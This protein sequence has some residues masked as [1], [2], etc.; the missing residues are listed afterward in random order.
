VFVLLSGHGYRMQTEDASEDVFVPA[1]YVPGDRGKCFRLAEL[2][3]YLANGLGPGTQFWFIDA[4]RVPLDLKPGELSPEDRNARNAQPDR[5]LLFSAAP[6]APAW[7]RSRFPT[8]L[9][10]A[11]GGEGR[12]KEWIEGHY[13]VTAPRVADVVQAAVRA[14]GIDVEF[15]PGSKVGRVWMVDPDPPPVELTVDVHGASDGD[16]YRLSLTG[17]RPPQIFDFRW[18]D[19][20]VAVPPGE[21]YVQLLLA[22]GPGSGGFGT[23]VE[24]RQPPPETMADLNEPTAVRFDRRPAP[25]RD[26]EEGRSLTQ[27]VAVSDP[28]SANLTIRVA[29]E[30]VGHTMIPV[31]EGESV[32]VELCDLDEPIARATLAVPGLRAPAWGWKLRDVIAPSALRQGLLDRIGRPDDLDVGLHL[33]DFMNYGAAHVGVA[34]T[35]PSALLSLLGTAAIG[36]VPPYKPV[37]TS[38]QTFDELPPGGSAVYVL[39]SG[40]RGT[41]GIT[42][43]PMMAEL[44]DVPDMPAV[45]HAPLFVTPGLHRL[46]ITIPGVTDTV[47]GTVA[48]PNRVTLVV[49]AAGAGRTQLYQ[50]ALPV[51]HVRHMGSEPGRWLDNEGFIRHSRFGALVQRRFGEGRPVLGDSSPAEHAD[52]W[53]ELIS[54]RWPDPLTVIVAAYEL[55]RRGATQVDHPDRAHLE[56]LAAVAAHVAPNDAVVLQ[57]LIRGHRPSLNDPPLVVDGVLAADVLGDVPDGM[58]LSYEGPWTRWRAWNPQGTGQPAVQA[59]RDL[60]RQHGFERA[61][62]G[63]RAL[64]NGHFGLPVVNFAQIAQ[65]LGGRGREAVGGAGVDAEGAAFVGAALKVLEEA[66]PESDV[67][68]APN[69]RRAALMQSFLAQQAEDT[70]RLNLAPS[71]RPKVVFD[72]QDLDWVRA[73]LPWVR[74]KLGV[75][76]HLVRPPFSDVAAPLPEEAR[77]AVLG[78]WGTGLYGAPACARSL[79]RDGDYDALVHLGDVYYTGT[80]REV[81]KHFLE[82]W[83]QIP[84]AVSRACNSNHEMYSGG[85]GYFGETLPAFAQPSSAFLLENEH[86]VL[87]GLDTAYHEADLD[88]EQLRWLDRA[89]A[90]LQGRRLVLFSHHPPFS[91]LASQGPLLQNKLTPLLRGGTVF[92]WYWGHE[93]LLAL[94]DRHEGWGLHGRCVGHSGYPYRR[95]RFGAA[96][97]V[98]LPEDLA[99]RYVCSVKVAPGAWA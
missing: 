53:N 22:A 87:A 93:H 23:L 74:G 15:K 84:K 38:F 16:E 33:D 37:V 12:A 90:R 92:A 27:F 69:D 25:L 32:D 40:G 77:L 79:A 42:S 47:V 86:W 29:E 78:D 20:R 48:V 1:D 50:F 44:V 67:L 26:A 91:Q 94:Y 55:V 58:V 39:A 88:D 65:L 72:E 82:P 36:D 31:R 51:G 99:L 64:T 45:T 3:A 59:D 89:V 4:C 70:G 8:V 54:G 56:H 62:S 30:N 83:P 43:D 98:E 76:T 17:R 9:H 24:A 41:L 5:H 80:G 81:R 13:W 63:G 95:P 66:P 19:N 85:E 11:L 68:S 97:R 6:D 73:F 60:H 75:P 21:Y 61:T 7:T 57:A 35:D 18:P 2:R 28:V 46:R 14:E 96:D 71:G 49:L 10:S 52:L 34:D